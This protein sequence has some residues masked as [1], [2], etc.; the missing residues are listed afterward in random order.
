MIYKIIADTVREMK[1]DRTQEE[2]IA[3]IEEATEGGH[4]QVHYIVTELIALSAKTLRK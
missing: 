1:N 3:Y 2:I 4:K